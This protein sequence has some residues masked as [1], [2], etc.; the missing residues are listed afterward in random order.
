MRALVSTVL[1][2]C[3][4]AVVPGAAVHLLLPASTVNE[5]V[6]TVPVLAHGLAFPLP[7][8]VALMLVGIVVLLLKTRLARAAGA[9]LVVGG[10]LLALS[11]TNIALPSLHRDAGPAG[12][13]SFVM[14]SWNALDHFDGASARQ[15]F[16]TL[17][18]DVA[19]LPELD[20]RPG[21]AENASRIQEA[22]VAGG[23]DPQYYDIFESPPTGTHIAP[24]T[25]IVAKDFADY[26]SVPVEQVNFG[27]VHLIPADGSAAPEILAFHTA[28]PVPRWMSEWT[29]D[30][31]TIRDFASHEGADAIMAGDLNATVRHGALGAVT[32]HG[33]VLATIPAINRGSWPIKAPQILRASIDH[34]LIPVDMYAAI[35]A[36]IVDVIGSD[37]A[38]VVTTISA[39]A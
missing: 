20:E 39:R 28:P 6:S 15:I 4:V 23:V 22:L 30:L 37:H 32:S 16:G 2:C 25:V 1:A 33:D 34:I 26:E 5:V 11:V 18:A 38:A 21:T 17:G 36:E 13:S 27:T 3:A 7:S 29:A 31:A 9:L 10:L 24:L 8:G 35:D 14:V 19:V 12:E